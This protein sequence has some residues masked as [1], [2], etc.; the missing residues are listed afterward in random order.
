MDH[1]KKQWST[2]LQTIEKQQEEE[3]VEEDIQRAYL[4]EER[5][6][7]IRL[8]IKRLKEKGRACNSLV[9]V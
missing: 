4:A 3:K 7:A 1:L 2:N 5:K 6:E 9:H 8:R